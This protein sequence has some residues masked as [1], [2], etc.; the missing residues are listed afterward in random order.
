MIIKKLSDVIGNTPLIEIEKKVHG[1]KN[2]NLYAKLELLNPYGSLKDRVAKNILELDKAKGKI[3]IESSSGNTAKALGGI[4]NSENLK[5]LTVT[6]RIKQPEI[7]EILQVMGTNIEEYQGKSDCPDPN[8]INDPIQIIEN[9][10]KE[11]PQKY[12][13]TDQYF[14]IKNIKA[15]NITGEEIF[16]DLKKIDYF[17]GYLGTCGSTRG[18]GE[19]LK[20]KSKTKIIG[21]YTKQGEYVPG[22]RDESELYESGLFDK[23]FYDDFES[24]T[25]NESI[26]GMLILNRKCGIPC[27]PTSGLSYMSVLKYLS[28]LNLKEEINVVFIVCD[29]LEPYMSYIKKYKPSIFSANKEKQED[30]FSQIELDDIIKSPEIEL[31]KIEENAYLIDIR[32]NFAFNFNNIKNSINI[33]EQTLIELLRNKNTF[34]KNRQVVLICPKGTISKKYVAVLEQQGVDAYSLKGGII[35]IKNKFT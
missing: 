20:E 26:E 18:V 16:S 4:C 13:H 31:E 24:G 30:L 15:H 6:N 32:S 2:V 1:L 12:F 19:I 33:P 29:R 35:G 14:N 8:D 10:V 23:L 27:G 17:F 5:F 25:I 28:N 34:P 9:K 7:R 21:I 3:V 11:N 22:G